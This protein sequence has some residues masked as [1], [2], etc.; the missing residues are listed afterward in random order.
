MDLPT[1]ARPSFPHRQPLLSGSFPVYYP[2]PLEGRQNENHNQRKLIKLITW[3]TVLSNSMKI[4]GMPCRATQ[5]KWVMLENS[6]KKW[7][8]GEGNANYF[9]LLALR[10]PW[11]IWNG[12]KIGHLKNELPRLVAAQYTTGNQWRNNSKKKEEMEPKWKQCPAVDVTG[13]GKNNIS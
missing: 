8:S 12:K 10:T 13:D 2:H 9:S 4:W 1:R 11:T 6:C 3:I 7:S 5:D